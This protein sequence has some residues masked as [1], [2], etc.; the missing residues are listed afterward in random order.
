[1]LPC[2][3]CNF[4]IPGD[5]RT[6]PNCG[7]DLALLA[8][9][10]E[11]SY[12]AGVPETAP[13]PETPA[14]FIPRI[15][16]Y[17]IEQDLLTEEELKTALARQKQLADEGERRLLG[18]T[19]VELGMVS[20]ET[21]DM[22]ITNQIIEL[23]AALQDAN[24]TL[25]L[26]VSERTAE[27]KHALARLTELNQLKTN[28]ISNVSHELRTP[29]AHIKGYVELLEEEELG[30]L[31]L[32]QG[33]AMSVIRRATV[34]L[35]QLIDDLISFSTAS[36]EGMELKLEPV[37][38]R[39]LARDIVDRSKPKATQEGIRL[40]LSVAKGLPPVQADAEKLSWVIY[41]L[42]DNAIKFTPEGGRVKL[43]AEHVSGFVTIAVTDTG[44]G[45]PSGKLNEVFQ[46]FHQ[47]DGSA[48]RRYRGTGLGLALVKQIIDAHGSKITVESMENKGSTFRFEL[49]ISDGNPTD[50]DLAGSVVESDGDA[51]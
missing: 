33:K 12:L 22:A 7:V 26:R 34:R 51:G 30:D 35:G 1:M 37:S 16:D 38:I 15:G 36:R 39:D 17:L 23:H 19:L 5:S 18:Q 46:P 48:T 41:Q 32:E 4:P 3:Q 50:D 8:L 11:R 27:L 10:A 13:L 28:L 44:I 42:L 25:E 2:P 9:L 14:A 49:P 45:I 21:I 40:R 43:W 29:L 31:T 20:R 24:R 47:L 6:C